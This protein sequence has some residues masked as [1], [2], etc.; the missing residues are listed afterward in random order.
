MKTTI[1]SLALSLLLLTNEGAE[2]SGR[3]TWPSDDNSITISDSKKELNRRIWT[4]STS[5]IFHGAGWSAYDVTQ[6]EFV[7]MVRDLH[8][9][10]VAYPEGKTSDWARVKIG[11]T[12]AIGG[13]GNGFNI[14]PSVSPNVL[15]GIGTH[16]FYIGGKSYDFFNAYV[17]MIHKVPVRGYILG[18]IMTGTC[19]ETIWMI[20]RAKP[21]Y[22]QLGLEQMRAE[23]YSTYWKKNPAL[24]KPK[25]N[26][27]ADSIKAVFP[28]VKLI[29]DVPPTR[30]NLESDAAWNREL[31]DG[32]KADGVRDYWHLHH[33]TNGKFTG[34]ISTDTAIMNAIFTRTLPLYIDKQKNLYPGKELV[35][36]Q[37]SVSLTNDGGTNPY[38]RT[39][40]GTS[41]I[42][43]MT[44]FM[45]EYNRDHQNDIASAK[46]ENLKQLIT[47]KGTGGIEYEIA[48]LLSNLFSEP[49]T[50]LNIQ[51]GNDDLQIFGVKGGNRYKV[52]VY[53]ESGKS[54]NLPSQISCDGRL[55]DVKIIHALYSDGLI[56]KNLSEYN[57]AQREIKPFSVVYAELR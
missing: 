34:G 17:D 25:F 44:K 15:Q 12:L 49:A 21:E 5:D 24:Y 27:W 31:H 18:N 48:K 30:S 50:V 55:L 1:L 35:V 16:E 47:N 3:N 13:S 54:L 4:F 11:D 2:D 38:K 53:N 10:A 19:A 46:Y 26:K 20:R 37:W 51:N 8:P 56:S 29:A 41:F 36:D 52:I 42:V 7:K 43:K 14:P 57:T 6:E 9:Y 39:F 22:V 32:L 33:L 23:A 45:I 28:K 40:F